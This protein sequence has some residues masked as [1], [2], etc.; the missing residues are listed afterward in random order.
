MVYGE[1]VHCLRLE[2]CS[3]CCLSLNIATRS[4]ADRRGV[5]R[6]FATVLCFQIFEPHHALWQRCLTLLPLFVCI[7]TRS[8]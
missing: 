5:Q 6:R 2:T 7:E 1:E 4:A 3:S 8:Y